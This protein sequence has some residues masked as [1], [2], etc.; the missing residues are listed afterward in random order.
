VLGGAGLAIANGLVDLERDARGGRRAVAVTLGRGRAWVLH[1]LLI[2][3]AASLA[4][5]LAPLVPTGPGGG[6]GAA[7]DPLRVLRL[8]GVLLGVG[9][10]A[11]G[12]LALAARRAGIRERGWELEAV[13]VACI[14]L[15][16]LAGTAGAAAGGG[17][18]V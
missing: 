3:G 5:V 14:G 4:V 16:W 15:G 7:L 12:A 13:G 2:G 6:G 18:G 1:A 17:A 9:F 10:I 8:G 11:L